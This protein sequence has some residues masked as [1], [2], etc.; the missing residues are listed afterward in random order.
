MLFKRRY[1][2]V[3][4]MLLCGIVGAA[5]FGFSAFGPAPAKPAVIVGFYTNRV[6]DE[7][8]RLSL[9][10]A[11]VNGYFINFTLRDKGQVEYDWDQT[12]TQ[13]MPDQQPGARFATMKEIFHLE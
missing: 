5:G 6:N 8:L 2:V 12:W 11:F 7:S 13:A 4:A 3:T 10:G 1:P 9:A